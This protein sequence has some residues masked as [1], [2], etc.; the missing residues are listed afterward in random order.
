MKSSAVQLVLSLLLLLPLAAAQS[1][2][3]LGRDDT[4]SEVSQKLL[5]DLFSA[6]S[7]L[8]W[9]DSS[10]WNDGSDI[11]RWKGITCYNSA[12]NGDDRRDGHVQAIDL[13]SSRLVGTV[14]ASIFSLPYLE[15][16]N[17]ENNPDVNIALE[18]LTQAQ[19]LKVLTISKTGV[20]SLANMGTPQALESFYLQ[21]LK[22]TGTIPA[23]IFSLTNLKFFHAND[24]SFS[25]P[26]PS[27]IGQL[28]K[29]EELTLFDSDLTG[30]LP[31]ELGKLTLL[32]VLTL[33]DNAF[34]GTLPL[35]AL[36]QMS[37]LQTLSIQRVGTHE[38]ALKG[39]GI[40]GPL[41]ALENHPFLT[42]VQF[43]N[44][45]L[46]GSIDPDFLKGS[47]TGQGIEVDLRNNALSGTVPA[48]L[49]SLRFLSLYLGG[50]Q[51]T[52]VPAQIY[53]R[54]SGTCSGISNWMNGDVASFGCNA[55]LCPPGT[56]SPQGRAMSSDTTCQSCGSSS[57][58]WGVTECT[59]SLSTIQREREILLN[60]YNVLDGRNWKNDDGWLELNQ[61]V[62]EWHGIGCD[63][64]TGRVTSIILRNNGLSGTVPSDLF[65]MPSLRVLN[66]ESNE[67]SFD[68]TAAA[69]AASL[70]SL[71]LTST[72][73]KS[74]T[75]VA[76]LSSLPNLTFLSVASNQLAGPIPEALYRMTQL[77]ELVLSHNEF[78]GPVNTLIGGM[79]SLKRFAANDNKLTGQLPTEIGKLY[80]SKKFRQL[81][82]SSL[83]LSLVL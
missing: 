41:P 16:F 54:S 43:E 62:C 5:S 28:T 11:C 1:D 2:L 47:P 9:S 42:K 19:F 48:S 31:G 10:N 78:S 4:S 50:N 66:L 39:S 82:T 35:T 44:Q 32:K 68:F 81:R 72:G 14:P 64:S 37:N 73:L 13:S 36:E 80:P 58:V 20:T 40:T 29:L 57:D 56:W 45:K 71:D 77:E 6:T 26:L 65:D 49:V 61:N 76:S 8:Q 18:G 25:G 59:S 33:T 38:A 51:I 69:N 55:F 30:Q 15:S 67:I 63:Q 12:N 74:L 3:N 21:D 27:A 24:N 60:F 7:G 46:S 52:S 79:T 22:L 75:G 70:E 23:V 34:D 83:E 53:D 17:V